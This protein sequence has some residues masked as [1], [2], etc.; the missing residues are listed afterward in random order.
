MIV[1]DASVAMKWFHKEK[2]SSLALKLLR[3]QQTGEQAIA[4]PD[5]LLIEIAN[6]I[7]TKSAIS[8]IGLASSLR[9]LENLDV[10]FYR[11]KKELVFTAAREAKRC[12]TSVYDMLYAQ[13]AKS[14]GA[15]LITA[16]EQFVRKTKFPYVKLLSEYAV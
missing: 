12:K 7:T 13:F 9:K 10:R 6:A 11:V 4:A 2:D 16:D 5:L 14:L 3:S 15:E 1:I 8:A